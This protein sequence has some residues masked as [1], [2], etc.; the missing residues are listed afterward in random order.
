[1]KIVIYI[2]LVISITILSMVIFFE[3]F[4]SIE[5]KRLNKQRNNDIS[6]PKISIKGKKNSKESKE[7]KY[8][9]KLNKKIERINDN[10][11]NSKK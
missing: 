11:E 4:S 1:M 2:Y 7:N 10:L 5:I 3:I 9:K 6:F 8:I